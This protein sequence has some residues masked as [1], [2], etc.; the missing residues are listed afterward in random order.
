MCRII[1]YI[2][3]DD[4]VELNYFV[5]NA[6]NSMIR[7]ADG[8]PYLPGLQ[9]FKQLYS[10]NPKQNLDGYGLYFIDL[11]G[12]LFCKKSKFPIITS[13]Q[14]K[15]LHK[16][17]VPYIDTQ[18]QY[19]HAFARNNNFKHRNPNK[20][21]DVQPY[22]Y[23]NFLFTHNGGFNTEYSKYTDKLVNYIDPIFL[24]KTMKINID[25]KW[26]MGLFVSM[27]DFTGTPDD[28]VKGVEDVLSTMYKIKDNG[29][30]ISLNIVMSDLN[31]DTHIALRYRTCKQLPPAMYYNK[32]HQLGYIVSSEPLDLEP[33]WKLMKNHLIIIRKFEFY[34][35]KLNPVM[36]NC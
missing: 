33:G 20:Y 3:K 22:K 9:K 19:L 21:Q 4:G 35:V 26:L 7:L 25:S 23:Q 36:I 2:G 1:L 8:E 32:I 16:R 17:L 28:I 31:N 5:Q 15:R 10:R 24:Q 34:S 18:I 27:V 29:F 30:N 12:N 11:E 13:L 14:N 6:P